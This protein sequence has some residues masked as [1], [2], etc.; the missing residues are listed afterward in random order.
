MVYKESTLKRQT[1]KFVR[2]AETYSTRR[3]LRASLQKCAVY[4]LRLSK[5]IESIRDRD[6][7]IYRP[8]GNR[9]SRR[10][11]R[12]PLFS[13][14]RYGFT[15]DT[16]ALP[17]LHFATIR[18][19]DR[20]PVANPHTPRLV[21][22]NKPLMRQVNPGSPGF[23]SS[24]MCAYRREALARNRGKEKGRDRETRRL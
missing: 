14:R 5:L 21:A 13:A 23:L 10:A 22:I 2:I 9:V 11:L 18:D 19:G 1:A 7:R 16:H 3:F 12:S 4:A 17:R 24:R 20:A 6:A 8:P 15:F